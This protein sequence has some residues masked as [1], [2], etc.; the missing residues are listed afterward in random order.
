MV[1]ELLWTSDCLVPFLFP[2][3]ELHSRKHI[4][5]LCSL[6]DPGINM[7]LKPDE[8]SKVLS[9]NEKFCLGE[10]YVQLKPGVVYKKT[11]ENGPIST[12][13]PISM[14]ILQFWLCSSSH[15]KSR[16]YFHTLDFKLILIN[17]PKECGKRCLPVLNLGLK[18]SSMFKSSRF[19]NVMRH[20]IYSF[21]F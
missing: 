8:I 3:F 21:Y 17:W 2:L 13:L 11:G 15:Q 7:M 9:W 19:C 18:R 5:N 10:R 14:L 16:V 20:M 4:R 12:P 1:S 6:Q